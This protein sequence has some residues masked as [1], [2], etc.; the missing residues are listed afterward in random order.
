[1]KKK[2]KKRENN[3]FIN[4]ST[5]INFGISSSVALIGENAIE[6]CSSLIEILLSIFKI[7]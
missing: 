6:N 2:K 3:A 1:M 7:C 4:C 5:L